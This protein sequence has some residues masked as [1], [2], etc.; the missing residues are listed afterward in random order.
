MFPLRNTRLNN[1]RSSARSHDSR[2]SIEEA[3]NASDNCSVQTGASHNTIEE[4]PNA[5][6]NKSIQMTTSRNR[7]VQ[8]PSW[9]DMWAAGA[10]EDGGGECHFRFQDGGGMGCCQ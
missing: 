5:I 8:R 7:D 4:I 10:A 6:H 9:A 2:N 3:D 1:C